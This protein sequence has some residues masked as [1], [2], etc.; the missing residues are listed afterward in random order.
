MGHAQLKLRY[1]INSHKETMMSFGH[2]CTPALSH[3][4]ASINT[5]LSPWWGN[6]TFLQHPNAR[7]I[8]FTNVSLSKGQS[9]AIGPTQICKKSIWKWVYHDHAT[10]LPRAAQITARNGKKVMSSRSGPKTQDGMEL[11]V[12]KGGGTL[13]F[14]PP[15]PNIWKGEQVNSSPLKNPLTI[16]AVR[17][18]S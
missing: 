8:A 1:L 4:G 10:F 12:Y 2:T 6:A 17:P 7:H 16:K 14:S 13:K 15:Y 11:M 3:Q 9:I 18:S 5:N